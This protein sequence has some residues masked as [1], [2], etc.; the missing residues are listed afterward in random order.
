MQSINRSI[1]LKALIVTLL[2]GCYF[3][4]KT[5][6]IEVVDRFHRDALQYLNFNDPI[7]TRIVVLTIDLDKDGVTHPYTAEGIKK[8]LDK[9]E[10]YGP[11]SIAIMME[12]LDFDA[13]P[14]TMQ[15]L[16]NL[17]D[18][19][20]NV[21]LN[22]YE[23]RDDKNL[24]FNLTEFKDFKHPIRFWRCKDTQDGK[25]NR[26][27]ALSIET[28][29]TTKLIDDLTAMG[30]DPKPVEYFKYYFD[31]WNST[32]IYIKNYPAGR[33]GTLRSTDLFADR[34]NKSD[35]NGKLVIIGTND[36]YSYMTSGSVFNLLGY[37]KSADYAKSRI[38]FHDLFANNVNTH[39]TGSYI[40]FIQNFN[41]LLVTTLFLIILVLLPIDLK[42]KLYSFYGLMP[43]YIIISILGYVLGSFYVDISRSLALLVTLQYLTIPMFMF[44]Y[45]REQE[46]QK[47]KALTDARIDAL[48]TISER[49]A[50]DLRSPL[51]TIKLLSTKARFED[52]TV[53]DLLS[54][55]ISRIEAMVDS[56]LSSYKTLDTSN[57]SLDK[58]N[59]QPII[60]KI[61]DEK[62]AMHPKIMFEIKS[63][64]T[65]QALGFQD[66]FERILSNIFDN[67]IRALANTDSPEVKVKFVE[68]GDFIE[69]KIADNGPGI[70]NDILK[71]LGQK[72]VS[73][74]AHQNGNGI[75]VLYAKRVINQ[76][77]GQFEISSDQ[78][79]TQVIIKLKISNN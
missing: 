56:I 8:L 53:Y 57:K 44:W 61:F 43:A 62:L 7:D 68:N 12:P 19:Y 46:R 77:G 60:Q 14:K 65:H 36:H 69:I 51:S 28:E 6:S 76:M 2:I 71:V 9:V 45:F 20:P 32:Q 55:S 11:K 18:S 48:L 16:R 49:V 52:S 31:Y 10:T 25:E 23:A 3:V 63:S 13:A 58:I 54:S 72:R 47:L 75:G 67:S 59:L 27:A 70:P 26:R 38:P 66:E 39:L 42:R 30:L 74:Y 40:K 78:S 15:N 50:H 41:D 35:L 22:Y 24:F 1:A 29:G 17:L 21:Y 73:G 64:C 79:G 34:T 4:F 33:Y 37:R 5:A